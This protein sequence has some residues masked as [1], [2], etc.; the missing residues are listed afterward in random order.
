MEEVTKK[1]TTNWIELNYI[2]FEFTGWK[3]ILSILLPLCNARA[4]KKIMREIK[5]QQLSDV[6]CL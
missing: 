5:E 2:S 6:F 4:R 3:Y 1:N